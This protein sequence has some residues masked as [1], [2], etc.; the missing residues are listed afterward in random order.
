MENALF[1]GFYCSDSNFS[2]IVSKNAKT[3]KSQIRSH[4]KPQKLAKSDILSYNYSAKKGGH[5]K[6][7][8]ISVTL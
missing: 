6:T 1:T 2:E 8:N 3:P 5:V 4:E 7:S